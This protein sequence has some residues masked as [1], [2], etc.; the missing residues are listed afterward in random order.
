LAYG[1]LIFN[2]VPDLTKRVAGHFL[3]EQLDKAPQI[4]ESLMTA[5]RPDPAAEP[6]AEAYHRAQQHFEARQPLLEAQVMQSL[7]AGGWTHNHLAM[8]TREL[9]L[10]INAALVLGDMSYLG[11]EIEWVEGLL[12]NHNIPGE[13]LP[14]FL[15]AYY[16]AVRDQL[17]KRGEPVTHWLSKLLNGAAHGDT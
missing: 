11:T 8:A 10:N 7:K 12:K 3:G 2:L 17:D 13:A 5:P 15:Q 9:N 16:R 4:I 6:V 14:T 1:G